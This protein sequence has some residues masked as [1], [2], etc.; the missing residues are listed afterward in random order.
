M[1]IECKPKKKREKK[2]KKTLDPRPDYLND[3]HFIL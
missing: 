2:K 3:L 1:S